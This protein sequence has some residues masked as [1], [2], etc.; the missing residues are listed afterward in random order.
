[1]SSKKKETAKSII[2]GILVGISILSFIIYS[3]AKVLSGKGLDYYLTGQGVQ[4]NYIGFLLTL[5]TLAVALFIGWLIRIYSAWKERTEFVNKHHG[6]EKT[7][8]HRHT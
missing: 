3:V 8:H 5:C 7:R 4:M 2:A 1:M 6:E